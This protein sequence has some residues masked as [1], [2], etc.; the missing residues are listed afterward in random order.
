MKTAIRLFV[1]FFIFCMAAPVQA[2]EPVKVEVLFMNHGPL[3]ATINNMRTV[4]AKYEGKVTVS[5]YD[6]DSQESVKFMQSKGITDHIP[7]LVWINGNTTHKIDGADVQFKGF[8]SGTG[9]AMFQGTWDMNMLGKAL[10][11]ATR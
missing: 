9:P 1:L 3:R 11:Q 5:W 6:F 2:A 10:D 7:L 4:F 8:P